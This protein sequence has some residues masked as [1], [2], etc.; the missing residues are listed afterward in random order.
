LTSAP[1][2]EA[3]VKIGTA[4]K[5]LRFKDIRF[6]PRTLEDLPKS[7]A[8]VLAFTSTTCP[9]AQRYLPT[10][11]RLE[12]D[13]RA[14]GVQ[15]VAVNV[16]AED[17]IRAMAA[18][19]VEYE[20][21]FPCVKDQDAKAAAALGVRRTPEVVVLDAARKLRY[22]GRIDDRYRLGG[23]RS[24]ATR[25]DL[26]EA[27]D[28]VLAGKEV[29]V[30]ETP[31][32]GCAITRAEIPPAKAPVTFAE[33]VAPLLH[34]H[35]V[36]CHRPGTAAPS[37]LLTYEQASAR[38][39]TIAEV[40]RDERMP[41]WYGAP[42]HTEFANRRGLSARERETVWQWAKGG[43][44]KGDEAKL[45]RMPAK[46][47][48][49][50]KI[51]K[52]DLVVKAPEHSLPAEGVVA[53]KYV[54]LPH[55]FPHETWVQGVQ[56]VPD[57]PKV[58]HH[59]NLAYLK[60][61]ERWRMENFITGAVPGGDPMVLGDGLGYRI[62]AGAVLM[63]Q[64]HYV[65]TGKK[66][67]CRISVALK[68]ASGRVDKHIHFHLLEDKKFAIPPG[69]P[70]HRVSASRVLA[71]DAVGLGLFCHMHLRGRDMTFKAHY[72]GGKSETL[73]VIPNY[74]FDWQMAYRWGRGAKKFPR[75]TR[76]EAIAHYDNSAFNPFNPNPK[77]T[78]RLG[79]QTADEMMNGFVFFLDAGEK[80]GLEIDG[81]T[82][83]PKAK[84]E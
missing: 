65:T 40:V 66:E 41:P 77:V 29:A 32:D 36:A 16:G 47:D 51:G 6:L 84:E 75:G 81:K 49:P 25:H 33:H 73:L 57:N 74:N 22:R 79:E 62:P 23:A 19:A 12:Q 1:A 3:E 59:C 15:F 64:V 42:K 50:W 70:A 46:E 56:I 11:K 69:A 38:A 45:P 24:E 34:K 48:S 80:L 18:H 13:Y 53:Y 83:R 72:P 30:P 2:A 17:S 14:R 44:L 68:Y 20:V 9:L 8:Y 31:V 10:L 54:I 5:K 39:N 21:E 61:G 76:L 63:L 78:V 35:C 7:K 28:A 60:L 58:L 43:K 37:S 52:P 26:K 4:V 82:G 71:C 67:K 27:L 55:V